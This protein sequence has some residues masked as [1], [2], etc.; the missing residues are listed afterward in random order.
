MNPGQFCSDCHFVFQRKSKILTI[1]IE[2][3]PQWAI[4]IYRSQM[5]SRTICIKELKI[6][7]SITYPEYFSLS[8]NALNKRKVFK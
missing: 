1:L 5:H 6:I 7:I 3:H 8:N 4:L 2:A